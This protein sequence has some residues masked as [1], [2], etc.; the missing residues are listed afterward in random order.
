[1]HGSP[2][3]TPQPNA[4]FFLNKSLTL[5][6]GKQNREA[7]QAAVL[8]GNAVAVFI[9]L[10]PI[11]GSHPEAANQR[12]VCWNNSLFM[13]SGLAQAL[14][15]SSCQQDNKVCSSFGQKETNLMGE[16]E[17][18]KPNQTLKQH[19]QDPL[20]FVSSNTHRR[21]ASPSLTP[22]R[23]QQKSAWS[24]QSESWLCPDRRCQTASMPS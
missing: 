18:V 3:I 5:I 2:S 21:S 19:E 20:G 11:S 14:H 22:L 17:S 6:K 23:D 8:A 4:R 1:M 16:V 12:G 10:G 13:S 9:F 24:Q 7:E 15:L